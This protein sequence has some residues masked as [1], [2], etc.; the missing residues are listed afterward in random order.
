MS[1]TSSPRL[2]TDHARPSLLGTVIVWIVQLSGGCGLDTYGISGSDATSGDVSA[3]SSSSSD[4]G[5]S[6]ASTA[7]AED[8]CG[9][10]IVGAD[11]TCDDGNEVDQDG[12]QSDCTVTQGLAVFSGN[13]ASSTCVKLYGPPWGRCWGDNRTSQLGYFLPFGDDASRAVGDAAD[14]PL[15]DYTLYLHEEIAELAM[16]IEYTCLRTVSGGVYCWGITAWCSLGAD[17]LPAPALWNPAAAEDFQMDLGGEAAQ[18]SAGRFG[19]CAVMVGGLLRC[20]GKNQYGVVGDG[21]E[22]CTG[23][24]P[25]TV[26]VGDGVEVQQVASGHA[27]TCVVTKAGEVKC[28]GAGGAGQLGHGKV[29]KATDASTVF[30]VPLN[31]DAH[32]V[33]GGFQHTCAIVGE[34]R[35][36]RCWG[37]NGSG[38]LGRDSAVDGSAPPSESTMDVDLGPDVRVVQVACGVAITCALSEVGEVFCWGR[39]D[40]GQLGYGAIGD[41]GGGA[42]NLSPL[43]AGP[44]QL[45]QPALQIAVGAYHVCALLRSGGLRCWGRSDVGQLGLGCAPEPDGTGCDRS[46]PVEIPYY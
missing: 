21:T 33:A 38:E 24:T 25:V 8:L 37:S 28:W 5:A 35:K 9:D 17:P 41:V 4:P 32:A 42:P 29:D 18:I 2:D 36:V 12:C 31:V 22:S 46:T 16:G 26:S 6:A 15:P 11:E 19:A 13:Y 39:N 40:Y 10:G 43:A 1:S 34:S 3:T 7:S 45:G 30:A 20:W 23:A 14:E 44:L 27:H